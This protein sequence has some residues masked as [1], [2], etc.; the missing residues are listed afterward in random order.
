MWFT[1]KALD[2]GIYSQDIDFLLFG[3]GTTNNTI[4]YPLINRLA[5]LEPQ[6]E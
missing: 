4:D 1:N 2:A 5:I 6:S 3:D